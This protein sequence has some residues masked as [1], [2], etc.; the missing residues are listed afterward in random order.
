MVIGEA[1]RRSV[2]AL[3]SPLFAS[4]PFASPVLTAPAFASLAFLVLAGVLIPA[5]A[6]SGQVE[7]PPLQPVTVDDPLRP[8]QWYLDRIRAPDAWAIT[9]GDP[10]VTIAVIDTGV[11]EEHRD[12]DGAFWRD[13]ETGAAGYDHVT[14]SDDTF[15][16]PDEDWHGTAAA[17]VAAARGDDGYGIAGV[18][19]EVSIMVRRIYASASETASPTQTSYGTA[20][21]AV[22]EAAADGAD[23]I[24][25]TWGGTSPSSELFSAIQ[26]SGVPVVVAAGNDG[27]DLSASPSPRR[28]PAMYRLPNLVTVAASDRG[29]EILATEGGGSNY[30]EHHV[31]L[32]APGQDIVSIAAGGAHG[33]F[34][35]TSFAAPQVAGALALGRS[36]APGVSSNELVAAVVSTARR[37]PEL[38]DRVTSGGVLDVAAFLRA[39]RRPAC[40]PEIPPTTFADVDRRNVHVGNIDC[41]VWYGVSVGVGA[42]RFAPHRTITRGEMAS[43]LARTLEVSGYPLPPE[44]PEVFVDIAGSTHEDAIELLAAT[45]IASGTGE[46]R[47]EPSQVVTREQMASFVVRTVET[48]LGREVVA[49]R[50]WFD[51]VDDSVHQEAVLSARELGI[52]LG[53]SSPR[54]FEPTKAMT[55]AQMASFV[56]RTLDALGREGISVERL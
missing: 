42:D 17:G 2:L 26:E 19:P 1:M 40:R 24:L 20:A 32:A 28:Y 3:A 54:E 38:A 49:E 18:A 12:L 9:T 35:G 23:V 6:A 41:V 13:P 14:D 31:D 34:E 16:G 44:P 45:G 22:R 52:T 55:R 47:F 48:V 11:D 43:F 4:P 8:L 39:V 50:D 7:D 36:I 37:T 29:N 46:G 53:S 27:Q 5:G 10:E 21:R 56:A 33:L 15:A 51:D 25:L 30:G